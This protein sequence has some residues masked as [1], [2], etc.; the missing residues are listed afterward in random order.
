VIWLPK[1]EITL[2]MFLNISIFRRFNNRL[3]AAKMLSKK[4]N[5]HIKCLQHMTLS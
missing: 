5:R 1:K 3:G 4:A 2:E